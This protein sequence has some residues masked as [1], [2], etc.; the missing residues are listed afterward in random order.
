MS[1]DV[2]D[3]EFTWQ[4]QMGPAGKCLFVLD[5]FAECSL[6]NSLR[7]IKELLLQHHNFYLSRCW[8][9]LQESG[10]AVHT[11]KTDAFTIPICRMEDA[12]G[13]LKWEAG[14]GS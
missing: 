1:K 14:I 11:I 13:L 9:L 7:F 2:E 12:E 10:V 5:L 6:N 3:A 4:L 8:R